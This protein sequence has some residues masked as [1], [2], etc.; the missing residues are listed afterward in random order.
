MTADLFEHLL[1]HP[2]EIATLEG[3]EIE[4]LAYKY[5]FCGILQVFYAKH[6][7]DNQAVFAQYQLFQAAISVVNRAKLHDFLE[8]KKNQ[9]VKKNISNENIEKI[10]K[11]IVESKQK[12]DESAIAQ[13]TAQKKEENISKNETKQEK[14]EKNITN[15]TIQEKRTLVN[16]QP[17]LSIEDAVKFTI[18]ENERHLFLEWIHLLDKI[19]LKDEIETIEINSPKKKKIQHLIDEFIKNEP[20][21]SKPNANSTSYLI[22]DKSIASNNL[23][24]VINENM[25]KI[26]IKQKNYTK[27]I[28]I[29]NKLIVK[30]PEKKAEFSKKIEDINT[31]L[32]H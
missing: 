2:E 16:L 14:V 17:N 6:T 26:L 19:A 4:K 10:K 27:A 24:D 28:E 29:Y 7:H 8:K 13:N 25:A 21:I 30:F 12:E 11:N 20:S 1:Q 32:N 9:I 31:Q 22:E 5:P 3:E 15:N 23:D 18:K